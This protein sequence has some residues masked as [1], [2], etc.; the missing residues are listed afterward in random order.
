MV[1]IAVT[2]PYCQSDQITKRGKTDTDKQRYRC[3]NPNCP[4]QS[5]LLH[6]VCSAI[7]GCLYHKRV[8]AQA[9]RMELG[10]KQHWTMNFRAGIIVGH[11][12]LGLGGIP[13]R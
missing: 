2:C 1:L 8:G 6:P 4:H 3:H 13:W 5:F 12:N 11:N 7:I 10:V 9:T